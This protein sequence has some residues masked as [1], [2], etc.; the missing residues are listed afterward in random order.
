[1]NEF[2]KR[3]SFNLLNFTSISIDTRLI[4]T[5]L[6][7]LSVSP[8]VNPFWIF[9]VQLLIHLKSSS[10][11]A[12][13]INFFFI[14]SFE[15]MVK[16]QL[17]RICP[18]HPDNWSFSIDFNGRSKID[19]SHHWRAAY[20]KQTKNKKGQYRAYCLLRWGQNLSIKRI[21]HFY[22]LPS[23]YIFLKLSSKTKPFFDIKKN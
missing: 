18:E 9:S 1:M 21:A 11:E 10:G 5:N 2:I 22:H 7:R 16:N 14:F 8:L 6:F 17:L 15:A 20:K 12:W 3:E 19:S 4:I 13:I 23:H